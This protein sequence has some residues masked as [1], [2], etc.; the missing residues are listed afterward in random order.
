MFYYFIKL[1]F[2]IIHILPYSLVNATGSSSPKTT[3]TIIT[4][5][6][7]SASLSTSSA[8]S[9]SQQRSQNPE[10][11]YSDF[12]TSSLPI[13]KFFQGNG[14]LFDYPVE[15]GS[16]EELVGLRLDVI[17]GDVWVPAADAFAPCS[18]TTTQEITTTLS[19]YSNFLVPTNTATTST[20]AVTVNMVG[21][22]FVKWCASLG[23]YSIFDSITSNFYDIYND[24][25]V[26]L[27]DAT[28]Y[29][30]TYMSGI[31]VAGVW[32]VDNFVI[33]YRYDDNLTTIEFTDVPFV[34]ANFSNTEVGALALGSSQSDYSY[35]RNFISNFVINNVIKTNSYSLLLGDANVTTPK[36]ILG[37]IN[38][39]NIGDALNDQYS[40][41]SEM[42]LFDFVPVYDE[43]MEII[44]QNG[45]VST[46]IPAFPIFG[47]GVS[48]NAT[49]QSIRFSDSYND[50]MTISTY[51]KPAVIDSRYYYNFIPYSTLI[52]MAVELNAV[53]SSDLDKWLVACSVGET[54]TINMFIGNYT[55]HIPISK[56][57]YRTSFNQYSLV[58][59]DGDDACNLAFLPDYRLGYSLMGTPLLKNIYLAIDNENQQ[60][61]LSQLSDQL[62]DADIIIVN[63][64]GKSTTPDGEGAVEEKSESNEDDNDNNKSETTNEGNN[65]DTLLNK[66]AASDKTMITPSTRTH[67]VSTLTNGGASVV[68][69]L[70]SKVTVLSSIYPTTVTYSD[71]QLITDIAKLNNLYAIESGEI[72]FATK[73]TTISNLTLTIPKSI[74]LT[75]SVIQ[76]TEVF[77]SNGEIYLQTTGGATSKR[78]SMVAETSSI[79]GFTSLVSTI[80]SARTSAGGSSLKVPRIFNL[81]LF[82]ASNNAIVNI[83]IF[84]YLLIIIAAFAVLL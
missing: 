7:S 62:D 9:L 6:T 26:S 25:V 61:A 65:H 5:T 23:T 60:L 54:G 3:P 43:T 32:A 68:F 13:L 34:Y 56:F 78:K 24:L 49:G 33:S 42:A 50:R 10:D 38:K 51:P 17:Q 14:V 21:S 41:V 8:S 74:V 2:I 80:R 15:I 30:K 63:L 55:I 31:F 66:R 48:S 18:A 82:T 12:S 84:S 69:E 72:P 83:Q 47:W 73:Y 71:D 64:N 22:V 53:Y 70:T 19:Y 59:E 58:F 27:N 11:K 40:I 44:P 1:F 76:S 28:N 35:T 81:Q 57:L 75:D 4:T 52:E 37:G 29:A 20:T 79:Y 67:G 39:N 45:G 46:S 36:V 77:I 16:N